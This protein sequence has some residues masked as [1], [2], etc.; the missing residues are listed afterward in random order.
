[1]LGGNLA[2]SV[3][4]DHL[5]LEPFFRDI[6]TLTLILSR[7]GNPLRP[8][9]PSILSPR[10]H[11]RPSLSKRVRSLPSP[12]SRVHLLGSR[13]CASE[14]V[15]SSLTFHSGETLAPSGHSTDI[16]LRVPA[17]TEGPKRI[18]MAK[19]KIWVTDQRVSIS[20]AMISW[21]V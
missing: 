9:C 20:Q 2:R 11:P 10:M 4:D 5:H 15:R 16:E 1:M 12:F 3:E 14:E 6:L 7:A 8:S 18:E 21:A 13:D 19:G 17:T